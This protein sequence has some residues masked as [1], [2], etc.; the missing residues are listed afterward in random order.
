MPGDR[1]VDEKRLQA[2]VEPAELTAFTEEDF[3]A[4]PA[5]RKGYIGPVRSGPTTRPASG[6]CSTRAS[7]TAPRGSPG[8]TRTDAT[9][10]T[11]SPVV[12]SPPTA[13]SRRPRCAPA[14]PARATAGR[15]RP[16]AASRWVTSSSSGAGSPRRSTCRVLDEN[17]KLVT[18]TMGSYGIG[19]SRAV[20]AIVENSHDDIGIIWPREVAPADV[21]LVAT[22]KDAAVVRLRRA[23]R[24]SSCEAAGRAGALRRPARASRPA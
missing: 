23:A 14:T 20:A 12:T 3:A 11:W 13:R 1:E 6:S 10:S 21:H 24:R 7:S 19:I 2:Q 15:S 22:G 18:V 17:G 8:P 9:C 5:L 16:R 4:N